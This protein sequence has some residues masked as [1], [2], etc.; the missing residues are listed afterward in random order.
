M[1]QVEKLSEEF[2]KLFTEAFELSKDALASY[3]ELDGKLQ[4][5]AKIVKYPARDNLD[6]DQGVGP[7]FDGGFFTFVRS[8]GVFLIGV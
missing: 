2:I 4:H 8:F 3:S 5:R 1:D 6:S 7:H